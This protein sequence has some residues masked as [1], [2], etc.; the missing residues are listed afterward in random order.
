MQ[1][2]SAG[3]TGT[4]MLPGAVFVWRSG[5]PGELVHG[6]KRQGS[7]RS[8]KSEGETYSV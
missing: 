6:A 1:E 7:G 2:W 8:E 4:G 5:G 3:L